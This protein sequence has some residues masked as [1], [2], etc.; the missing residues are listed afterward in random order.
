MPHRRAVQGSLILLTSHG[1]RLI[2]RYDASRIVAL[3][4]YY[5]GEDCVVDFKYAFLTRSLTGLYKQAMKK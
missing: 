1:G 4:V 2:Q 5:E 3:G